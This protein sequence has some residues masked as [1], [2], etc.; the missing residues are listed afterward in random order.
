MEQVYTIKITHTVIKN[1][2]IG[3]Y[4]NP[5]EKECL[6]KIVDKITDG[7]KKD[8]KKENRYVVCNTDEPYVTQVLD[9]IQKAE[10]N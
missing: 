4:L 7:R 3:K 9:V 10:R 8:G 1:E 5:L 6:R 2:D